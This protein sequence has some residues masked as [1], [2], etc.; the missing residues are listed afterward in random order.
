VGSE[1]EAAIQEEAQVVATV[2]LDQVVASRHPPGIAGNGDDELEGDIVG[3][4]LEEM[5]VVDQSREPLLD[6]PE[7]RLQ[8]LEVFCVV[9]LPRCNPGLTRPPDHPTPRHSPRSLPHFVR[10]P[11]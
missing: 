8:G 7:E 4:E 11:V 2:E 1:V 9:R 10:F 3:Q 5:A 6:H